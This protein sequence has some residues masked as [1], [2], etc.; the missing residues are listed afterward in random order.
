V[1]GGAAASAGRHHAGAGARVLDGGSLQRHR[2][3]LH[4]D[5]PGPILILGAAAAYMAAH[6]G[7][8]AR[9]YL[10]RSLRRRAMQA[11][12]YATFSLG[13]AL[14]LHEELEKAKA[15][16]AEAKKTTEAELKSA[17]EAAVQEFLGSEEHERRLVEEALKGYERGLEDMKR[18]ALRLRP[19]VD[20]AQ[21][22]VPPGGFQ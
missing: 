7:V 12:N 2:D 1:G 3:K 14:K 22:F 6:R 8:G 15:E 20:A 9:T 18:V 10:C 11:A 5:A 17:K 21:L 4:R 13:H 16:L 19:D